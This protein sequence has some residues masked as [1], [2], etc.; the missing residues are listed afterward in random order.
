MPQSSGGRS[1]KTTA[2]KAGG[3]GKAPA[4]KAAEA[5]PAK[6]AAPGKAAVA[7]QPHGAPGAQM[8]LRVFV[9]N[10]LMTTDLAG[11]R[12]FYGEVFGWQSMDVSP[13]DPMQPAKPGEHSSYSIWQAGEP[14][15]GQGGAMQM[16]GPQFEGVPPNWL[17]YVAVA[18]ADATAAKVKQAGGS[19]CAGPIEVKNVGRLYI[20]KDPQGAVIGIGQFVPMGEGC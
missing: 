19:I 4:A 10:E 17:A 15:T 5:S 12:R 18:D 14:Q 6:P 1:S 20:I 13:E 9:W 8:P 11:A 3:A 2:A 7:E 16:E